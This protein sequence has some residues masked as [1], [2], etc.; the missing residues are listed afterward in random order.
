MPSPVKV[1]DRLLAMAR[2][3]A[4]G[5][6]RSA[7]AQIEHWATLGRAIE[8]LVAYSQVLALKRA[9]QALP[10]PAFVSRDE[11]HDLLARL[12]DDVDRETVKARIR[13]TGT[14]VYTADPE[15]PG[16]IVEVQADGTRTVG[17]LEGRRF[18]PAAEDRRSSRRER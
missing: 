8:V 2:E 6:H 17:R 12:V 14:P 7:T 16:M 3:E 13:S 18:V 5:T 15:H 10:V 9:G 11:V 4:K 1:S